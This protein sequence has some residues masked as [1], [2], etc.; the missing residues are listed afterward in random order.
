MESVS[1]SIHSCSLCENRINLSAEC[2]CKDSEEDIFEI[3]EDRLLKRCNL[4]SGDKVCAKHLEK[5]K[6]GIIFGGSGIGCCAPFHL[7][8]PSGKRLRSVPKP[9]R[10]HFEKSEPSPRQN[11]RYMP[12]L[13][14]CDQCYNITMDIMHS[15]NKPDDDD[16]T[17]SD[18]DVIISSPQNKYMSPR[19]WVS[20]LSMQCM[21]GSNSGSTWSLSSTQSSRTQPTG[22]F[23]SLYAAHTENP[24]L[25][26]PIPDS[27][28]R[29]FRHKSKTPVNF[30]G[31]DSF[32]N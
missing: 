18:Y 19:K 28:R 27:I 31:F 14:I 10:P 11:Q 32:S 4:E 9:W 22:D 2:C 17:D 5:V 3:K 23:L 26:Q 1:S 15:A 25:P 24:S 12:T 7:G 29:F 6:S 21:G 16:V 8:T 30:N 13:Q 20:S